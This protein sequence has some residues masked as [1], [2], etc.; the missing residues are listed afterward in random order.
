MP[1]WIAFLLM[2]FGALDFFFPHMMWYLTEG[3]KFRDAEPS[4]AYLLFGRVI[5]VVLFLVGLV[6]FING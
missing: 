2:L 5:G 4:D 3:W 6:M 1:R